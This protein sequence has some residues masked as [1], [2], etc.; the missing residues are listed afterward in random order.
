MAQVFG[1]R[2]KRDTTLKDTRTYVSGTFWVVMNMA[3]CLAMQLCCIAGLE[4]TILVL[5][6][7]CHLL[8]SV[9]TTMSIVLSSTFSF[10]SFTFFFHHLLC[11]PPFSSLPVPVHLT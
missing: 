3:N 5:L 8:L 6:Y 4:L 1:T 10:V 9:T 2:V 7:Y 11:F